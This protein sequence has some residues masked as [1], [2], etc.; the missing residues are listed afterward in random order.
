LIDV[1]DGPFL[2]FREAAKLPELTRDGRKPHIASLY[3]WASPGGVRGVRLPS[4]Q[5]GGTRCTTAEAVRDFIRELT[6]R[7]DGTTPATSGDVVHEVDRSPDEMV[8]SLLHART[9]RRTHS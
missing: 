3:R 9:R 1:C 2:T 7:C 6:R 4:W 5:I 8:E